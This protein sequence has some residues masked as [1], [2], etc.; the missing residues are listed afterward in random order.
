MAREPKRVLGINPGTRYLGLA[1][2]HGSELLDWRVKTF[3]GKWTKEK[4]NKIL[5]AIRDQ[6]DFHGINAISIKKLHPSRSS[7]NLKLLVSR[8]KAFARR[9][10]IKVRSYS[11]KE[12]ERFFL[13]DEKW[14]KRNM[15]EEI[16]RRCPDLYPD[17][18]KEKSHR[19]PC[20]FRIFE[21]VAVVVIHLNFKISRNYVQ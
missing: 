12:L 1:V 19:N 13:A 17:L 14:N 2:F 6:I 10:R 4:G 21:A 15:I 20:Y 5:N 3:K 18:Q 8:I 16:A 7:K 9:K 11:I